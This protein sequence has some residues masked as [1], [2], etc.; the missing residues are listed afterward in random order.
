MNI[1]LNEVLSVAFEADI[2]CKLVDL[3]SRGDATGGR[4]EILLLID[5][6][7][8]QIIHLAKLTVMKL[9]PAQQLLLLLVRAAE[10]VVLPRV[11]LLVLVIRLINFLKVRLLILRLV[12]FV[13]FY[14]IYWVAECDHPVLGI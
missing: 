9:L 2:G 4:A 10:Q 11:L 12:Q 5:K 8:P 13:L 7:I 1:E 14:Q 3:R 6:L